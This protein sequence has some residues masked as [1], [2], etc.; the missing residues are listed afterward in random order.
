MDL[1]RSR[2]VQPRDH[3]EIA[4]GAALVRPRPEL[5]L[6]LQSRGSGQMLRQ[7]AGARCRLR[8]GALGHRLCRRA[9]TTT[10]PGTSTIRPEKPRHWRRPTMPCSGRSACAEGATPVEQALDPR[11]AGPLPAARADRG[12]VRLGQGLSPRRCA[13]FSRGIS[14]DLDVRAVFTDAI[15]N[16]TP[17]QMWDLTT[18]GV[19]KD[20]GTAE[21]VEVLEQA[22][23]ETSGVV[24]PSRAAASLCPSDGDVALP[25]ARAARRRPAARA[26]A[27]FGPSGAHADPH[28]RAVR[29]L[30]RR[31][32][33]QPEGR[34]RRSQVPRARRADEH[35]FD[36]P[37]SQPS[38]RDLRR[39]VPRPVHAGH[40]GGAGADRHHAGGAAAHR[41]AAHGR[42]HRGLH[43]DEAACAGALRQMA[44]DH[45][46]GAARGPRALLLDD[47]DDALRQGR[48][49]LG[50]G[51]DRRGREGEGGASSRPRRACPKPGACTTTPSRTCSPSARRC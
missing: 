21:A 17:W 30:S 37:Q 15:M 24:G 27:R 26:G 49:A 29:P 16:E 40:R 5:G 43:P 18:G 3:D 20:A 50:A 48:G 7:G 41:L 39:D 38:F 35:L 36:V 19:A 34:G 11:P 42:L 32:G 46:P 14:D 8:H 44:R 13:R 51:R 12:P 33:L 47:G 22:F 2:Q 31:R 6:C 23:R 45:R 4:R 25:A 28:R 1:L 9:R 10:C